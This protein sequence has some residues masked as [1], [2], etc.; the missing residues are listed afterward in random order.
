MY[1]L[2]SRTVDRGWSS[3]SFQALQPVADAALAFLSLDALLRELLERMTEI[4]QTDTAAFRRL[5]EET[6]E[7]VAGAAKGV[8]EE[9]EQGVRIPVGR[10]SAGRIAAE[11]TAVTI[12]D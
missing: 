1:L 3:E 2:L 4:L 9:V 6:D 8:E 11:R 12:A 7:L 5:D 10:G